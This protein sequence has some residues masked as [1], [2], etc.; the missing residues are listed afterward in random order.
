M[1]PTAFGIDAAQQVN[2]T[3]YGFTAANTVLSLN[4]AIGN[5]T[6]VTNYDSNA[7]DITGAAATPEPA[8][9][10]LLII[11]MGSVIVAK[12]RKSKGRQC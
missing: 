4:V 9:F 2:G 11:G 3:I 7:L 1:S 12:R 10:G 8:S 6:F 5:T